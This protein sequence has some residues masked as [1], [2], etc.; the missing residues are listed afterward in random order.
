M[1]RN[2]GSTECFTLNSFLSALISIG[3][4]C[5]TVVKKCSQM[6]AQTIG[7]IFGF[8]LNGL[9][10][11]A[12]H[13]VVVTVRVVEDSYRVREQKLCSEAERERERERE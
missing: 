8:V 13:R 5:Q 11:I 12:S 6:S 10:I 4:C 3:K 1:D 2:W 9:E 7:C